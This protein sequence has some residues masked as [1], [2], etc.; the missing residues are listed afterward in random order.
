VRAAGILDVPD[1]CYA[2]QNRRPTMS[3]SPTFES[4]SA[5]FS[6]MPGMGAM[7]DTL[8]FVKNMWGGGM[9]V[10]GMA[11][12]TLSVES[13]RVLDDVEHEHAAGDDTGTRGAKRHAY[14]LEVYGRQR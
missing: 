4:M 6:Q 7:N 5:N 14:H 3:K 1:I 13:G 12:P 11:M 9:K 2:S 8:E 10:P